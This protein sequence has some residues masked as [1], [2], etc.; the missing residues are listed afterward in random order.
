MDIRVG[1]SGGE[2]RKKFTLSGPNEKSIV[3]SRIHKG[4]TRFSPLLL[5]AS[6]HAYF[7]ETA[8]EYDMPLCSRI[9][10]SKR[11][12]PSGFH[13]LLSNFHEELFL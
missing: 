10:E 1:R 2:Y 4:F 3:I 5:F 8:E 7:R 9:A 6:E 11:T 13:A 12:L